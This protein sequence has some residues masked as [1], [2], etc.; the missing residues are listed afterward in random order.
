MDNKDVTSVG[1]LTH[2]FSIHINSIFTIIK[3]TGE[4]THQV[5]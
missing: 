5:S 1:L 3:K 2:E 4:V